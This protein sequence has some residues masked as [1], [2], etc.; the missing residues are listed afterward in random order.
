MNEDD[1]PVRS[2][3]SPGDGAGLR[4]SGGAQA[5][6]EATYLRLR[7]LGAGTGASE[8][9]VPGHARRVGGPRWVDDEPAALVYDWNI[10]AE[11]FAAVRA[12][13]QA[14]RQLPS[15]RATS[16]SRSRSPARAPRRAGRAAAGRRRGAAPP[17]R[18]DTGRD[19][20][21]RLLPCAGHAG[22]PCEL[23]L[24]PGGPCRPP[25]RYRLDHA[26]MPETVESRPRCSSDLSHEKPLRGGHSRRP[27]APSLPSSTIRCRPRRPH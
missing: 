20:R 14:L 12:G 17:G 26:L 22:G 4:R 16:C 23:S 8:P 19:R 15:R 13:S 6:K 3:R 7:S 21:A 11:L 25:G 18:N 9:D 27:N 2:H 10:D 5:A 24:L 1:Q